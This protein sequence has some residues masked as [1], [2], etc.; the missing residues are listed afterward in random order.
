MAAAAVAS[1][2][3]A[4]SFPTPVARPPPGQPDI[5]YAPDYAKYTARAARRVQ[6]ETLPSSVPHGFPQQL[7][8]DLVWD[9]DTV[10]QTYDWV[11]ALTA[12]QLAEIDAAVEHFKCG[13][14]G[15]GSRTARG[16]AQYG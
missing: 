12:D 1:S 8:G 5:Q 6:T 13:C 16:G 10:G 2:S 3:V 4:S 7:Q 9:G 11:F 14:E 15:D